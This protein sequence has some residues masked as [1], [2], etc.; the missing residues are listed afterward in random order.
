M[1]WIKVEDAL[2]E[3]D[4]S[5]LVYSDYDGISIGY[6]V[7]DMPPIF[8]QDANDRE[9]MIFG[10]NAELK[11]GVTHWMPLPEPPEYKPVV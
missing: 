10:Y 4:V 6:R 3:K 9:W 7:T 8:S 2:P 5:V 11:S 1:S